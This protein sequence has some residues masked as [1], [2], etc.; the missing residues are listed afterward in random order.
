MNTEM[1]DLTNTQ[2]QTPEKNQLTG[3]PLKRKKHIQYD[4][5]QTQI[6]KYNPTSTP[7]QMFA[8]T[9]TLSNPQSQTHLFILNPRILQDTHSFKHHKTQTEDLLVEDSKE[10]EEAPFKDPKNL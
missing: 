6:M 4:N 2:S 10:A 8:E 7:L 9:N 3:T 1:V 5:T